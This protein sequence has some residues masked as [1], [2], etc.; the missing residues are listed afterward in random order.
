MDK[1]AKQVNRESKKILL[2]A[3]ANKIRKEIKN[4]A[5]KS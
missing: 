1:M 4:E 5:I 3:L 2:N